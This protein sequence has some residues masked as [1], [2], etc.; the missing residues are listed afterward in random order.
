M[1]VSCDQNYKNYCKSRLTPVSKGK[2]GKSNITV[3][4]SGD[5]APYFST[6]GHRVYNKKYI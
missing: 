1:L 5:M 2:K 6:H 4:L 3:K